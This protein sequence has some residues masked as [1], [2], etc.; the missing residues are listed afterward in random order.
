M[1]LENTGCSKRKEM[2]KPQQELKAC[3]SNTELEKQPNTVKPQERQ[4]RPMYHAGLASI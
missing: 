1:I 4:D 2:R 3:N